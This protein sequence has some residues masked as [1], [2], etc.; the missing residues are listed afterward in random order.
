MRF[1]SSP[2]PIS[3]D[4]PLRPRLPGHWCTC[5][6]RDPGQLA[7]LPPCPSR[8]RA[9]QS[10]G[11]IT[12]LPGATGADRP[13]PN[14]TEPKPTPYTASPRRKP[15]PAHGT[16]GSA[17]CPIATPGSGGFFPAAGVRRDS[18]PPASVP[19]APLPTR[20]GAWKR[21]QY[22]PLADGSAQ[23]FSRGKG[24]RGFALRLRLMGVVFFVAVKSGGGGKRTRFLEIRF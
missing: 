24:T 14:R 16:Q 8:F 11:K 13:K 23:R 10:A 2:S 4:P 1:R 18:S 22:V 3:E 6:C 5:R 7:A 21:P 17:P 15:L 19:V 12:R 20:K 9:K